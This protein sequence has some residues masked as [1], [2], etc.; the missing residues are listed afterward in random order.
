LAVPEPVA[1][2]EPSPETH[3][4]QVL[5]SDAHAETCL[6]KVGDRMPAV[7]LTDIAGTQHKLE[8]LYGEEF[9]VIVFWN[10]QIAAALEQFQRLL[11]D[12]W[13]PWSQAGVAV[14]AINEGDSADRIRALT[15]DAKDKIVNLL[16][17]DGAVFSQVATQILPRT[18]LVDQQ[19][20]ILWF[21]IEYS[22]S[23]QRELRNALV[24][25]LRQ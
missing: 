10:G 11:D 7:T 4:P 22:Q 19:G 2:I 5:L 14:L 25:Y 1:T 9:T 13:A 6:L 23:T 24:Y 12:V 15:G 18:Y 3:P 20:K 8:H 16:D 21:D 17:S